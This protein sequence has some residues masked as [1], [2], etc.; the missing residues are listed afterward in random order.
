MFLSAPVGRHTK[1]L[2]LGRIHSF[3]Q[4]FAMALRTFRFNPSLGG[5]GHESFASSQVRSFPCHTNCEDPNS[6]NNTNEWQDDEEVVEAD[7][8]AQIVK[9]LVDN[10]MDACRSCQPRLLEENESNHRTET[11]N[12]KNNKATMGRPSNGSNNNKT[13]ENPSTANSPS[14]ET[15]MPRRVLVKIFPEDPSSCPNHNQ[16]INT[17]ATANDEIADNDK[18][19]QE[20]T[21]P[22]PRDLLR[23]TIT[24]NGCGMKDIQACV[25]PFYTNKAHNSTRTPVTDSVANVSSAANHDDKTHDSGHNNR[26]N[27]AGRYGIGLTR[28]LS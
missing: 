7:A 4:Q 12:G 21:L 23:V 25:D 1:N 13:K 24:D 17:R 5:F 28:K 16:K 14:K 18:G 2:G 11:K 3:T 10:A 6:R 26:N 27:T 9:E 15:M 19:Q 8:F 22:L 20:R